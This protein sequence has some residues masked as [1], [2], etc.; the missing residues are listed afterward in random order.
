MTGKIIA[1]LKILY[2]V[3]QFDAISDEA[4]EQGIEFS[5]H[6]S[7]DVG[8]QRS[9]N[10]G[11]GTI[12]HLDRYMEFLAGNPDAR[13]DPNIIYFGYDLSNDVDENRIKEAA[14]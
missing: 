14:R 8:L 6:I 2:S 7:H 4:N 1:D 5:G 9:L 3:E 11:P 12:D 10:A 13:E